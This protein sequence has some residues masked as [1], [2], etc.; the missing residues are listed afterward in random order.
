MMMLMMIILLLLLSKVPKT[1]LLETYFLQNGLET[2]LTILMLVKIWKFG[3]EYLF[4]LCIGSGSQS[5]PFET[6][7]DIF[8]NLVETIF[9]QHFW[10]RTRQKKRLFSLVRVSSS[11]F[12]TIRDDFFRVS[13]L[14]KNVSLS[15]PRRFETI[16]WNL[17]IKIIR[18]PEPNHKQKR[19][20]LPNFNIF[21]NIEIVKMVSRPVCRK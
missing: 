10:K 13:L 14:K 11:Q 6:I 19:Y 16:F 17:Q 1:G 3:V 8:C 18:K 20:S 7:R 15:W 21:T 12:E 4:C 5:R 9:L 2:I